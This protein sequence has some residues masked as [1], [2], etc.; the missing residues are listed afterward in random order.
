[1]KHVAAGQRAAWLS[2]DYTGEQRPMMRA[3]VQRLHLVTRPYDFNDAITGEHRHG[4]F[5]SIVFA[6]NTQPLEL[7]NLKSVDWTRDVDN[8]VPT[9][10]LV[11][12]NTEQLRLGETPSSQEDFGLPGH[13]TTDRGL[14]DF[15]DDWDWHEPSGWQNRLRPDY[16]IHT[17]EGYGFDPELPPEKDPHMSPSGVWIITDV[18]IDS[19]SKLITVSV[20]DLLSILT[21]SIHFPP[22]IPRRQYPLAWTHYTE[23]EGEEKAVEPVAPGWVRP[24]YESDSNL[25][26]IGHPEITDAGREYVDDEGGVEGH[27]GRHAFDGKGSTYWLSVGN[28]TWWSSAYEFVQ[29]TIASASVKAVKVRVKGGP[30]RVFVSVFAGG[31]WRGKSEIPYI[32][33]QV[34]A[35]TDI[36]YVKSVTIKDDDVLV[37]KLPKTYTDVTKVRVTLANLWDSGIGTNYPYRAAVHEVMVFTGSSD[38]DTTT[39]TEWFGNYED[40]TDIIK[41]YLA[42]NGWWWPKEA[43]HGA[44]FRNSDGTW[45]DVEPLDFEPVIHNAGNIWGDFED[46]GTYGPAQLTI[47]LFDKKPILDAIH[48]IRDIIGW[49]FWTDE[50][51]GAI[52]RQPNIYEVGNYVMP[53]SGGK[54]DTRTDTILTIDETQTPF[55]VAITLSNKN[56]RQRVIVGDT[57]GRYAASSAGFQPGYLGSTG[58]LLVSGLRRVGM[59][60][61]QNFQ[62]NRECQ[63]M[64]DFITQR[65]AFEYR[66]ATVTIPANPEIQI[67]DQ[68]RLK[69]RVAEEN[70]IHYVRSIHSVWDLESGR[71]TY[72]LRTHWLGESPFDRW[73]FDPARMSRATRNYLQAIGKWEEPPG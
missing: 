15:S 7:P 37:I 29:G 66:T 54:Y 64:A 40:Y 56:I 32:Y 1:M 50:T 70:Y 51:G 73:A 20:A 38:I 9:G 57:T 12:Y 21:T 43:S 31:Q 26:Y 63:V 42:W 61:D 8:D 69:E 23:V 39:E 17:F 58:E 65:Q 13:F 24:T 10:T 30:Y 60:T 19:V 46:T 53:V 6:Q 3:T 72:E 55:S 62:S 11:F 27:Y 49:N 22:N 47:D 59:W 48:Y 36:R 28:R 5:S 2:G 41:W 14:L 16:V 35:D 71:W 45:T 33:R 25:P 4:K 67:D 34:D 44:R 68:I 18:V 52:W